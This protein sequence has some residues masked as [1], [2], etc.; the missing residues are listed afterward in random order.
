MPSIYKKITV[1]FYVLA[2][3]AC[4]KVWI[5]EDMQPDKS[6]KILA[7]GNAYAGLSDVKAAA[8]DHAAKLCLKGYE[9]SADLPHDSL[10]PD[11]TLIVMCK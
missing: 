5:R 6:Y 11:Y 4:A 10:K 2:L 8:Y 7:E 9:K 3:T 1:I